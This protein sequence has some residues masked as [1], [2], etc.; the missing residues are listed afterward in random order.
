MDKPCPMSLTPEELMEYTPLWT[1]P[2]DAAGRPL[3]QLPL[4]I[5]SER[6]LRAAG[7]Y[8]GPAGPSWWGV[9]NR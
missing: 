7:D 3:P 6:N 1:G 2:R 9:R 5:D 8:S 4:T